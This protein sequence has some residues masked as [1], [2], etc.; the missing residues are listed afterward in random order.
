MVGW[1]LFAVL[2]VIAT[3]VAGHLIHPFL[4][5]S[6]PAPGARLLVV[7]GW[8]GTKELD[9]AVE[10]AIK[11]KYDRI[12]TTGGPI[13]RW[14][15]LSS[16]PNYA[17]LAWRYLIQHGLEDVN[18]TSVPAP[19]SAQDRTFLSAVKLRQWTQ[20]QG[21]AVDSFDVFTGDTHARRSRILYQLAFGEG[22]AVGVMAARSAQYDQDRW[23]RSSAG[24][25]AVF[26]EAIAVAWTA[27]CFYPPAPNSHE[28]LWAVPRQSR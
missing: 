10:V 2:A 20:K 11:G 16:R 27:C 15:E 8:L 18:L 4:A 26:G 9:Q 3:L 12:V 23:W 5:L 19:A 6:Q 21:L 22:V 14:A 7:E 28:E 25:K 13:E 24:A 17:D 1:I